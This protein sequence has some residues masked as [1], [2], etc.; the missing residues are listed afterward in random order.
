MTGELYKLLAVANNR[1]IL[2]FVFYLIDTFR[3]LL[4]PLT[5][6]L[7]ASTNYRSYY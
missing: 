3:R 7:K 5:I 1:K 2:F 6:K 4:W